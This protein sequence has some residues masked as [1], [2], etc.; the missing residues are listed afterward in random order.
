MGQFPAMQDDLAVLLDR[1]H[2]GAAAAGLGD[3]RGDHYLVAL[4]CGGLRQPPEPRCVDAVVVGDQDPCHCTFLI[5]VSW[6]RSVSTWTA[7]RCPVP[8]PCRVTFS[9]PAAAPVR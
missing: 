8:S 2:R 3:R 1:G 6:T 9:A 7:S 4:S 5:G